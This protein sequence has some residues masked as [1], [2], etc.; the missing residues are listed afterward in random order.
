MIKK[1][2]WKKIR[3]KCFRTKSCVNISCRHLLYMFGDLWHPRRK[4]D[5]CKCRC[6][7]GLNSK[8]DPLW[9][10][11]FRM[12]ELPLVGWHHEAK[13]ICEPRIFGNFSMVTAKST[14]NKKKRR[15]YNLRSYKQSH[16]I[17][18]PRP[19]TWLKTIFNFFL[20]FWCAYSSKIQRW[21]RLVT[22]TMSL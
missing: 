18:R 13:E 1:N 5:L 17:I 9:R 22:A 14:N 2:I 11:F 7:F 16:K 20:R 8:S 6:R 4:L 3:K 19:S 21:K 10:R 15:L 12:S